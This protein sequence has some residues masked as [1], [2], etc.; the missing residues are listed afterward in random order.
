MLIIHMVIILMLDM[1]I[2]DLIMGLCKCRI[3]TDKLH[4]FKVN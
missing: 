2:I 4:F 1:A 3:K